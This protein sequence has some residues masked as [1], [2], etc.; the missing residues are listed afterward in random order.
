MLIIF[1][2]Q[3]KPSEGSLLDVKSD[4][5]NQL[6]PPPSFTLRPPS[7]EPCPPSPTATLWDSEDKKGVFLFVYYQCQCSVTFYIKYYS[8]CCTEVIV[9]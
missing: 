8:K 1:F 9:I 5:E 7:C 6:L 3:N 2:L 4:N